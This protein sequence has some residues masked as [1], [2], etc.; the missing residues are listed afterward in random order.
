[1]LF[2]WNPTY[3]ENLYR[4]SQRIYKNTP[5]INKQVE[6]GCRLL[7]QCIKVNCLPNSNNE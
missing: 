7:G 4:K 2:I 1:M 6:Q 5:G 3:I